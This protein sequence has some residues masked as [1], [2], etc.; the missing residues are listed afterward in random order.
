MSGPRTQDP[1]AV[2]QVTDPVDDLLRALA[3]DLAAALRAM[4]MADAGE[5][6]AQVVVDLGHRADRRARVADG[7]LLVDGDGR[8]QALDLVDVRLLHLAQ[9]LARVRG[10]ALDVATLAL[11]VDGVEG[12]AA[13][14]APGQPG[15]DDQPITRQLDRDVLEVV[16]ARAAHDEGVL[17]H[18]DSLPEDARL[19]QAFDATRRGSSD[20]VAAGPRCA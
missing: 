6:Q 13:L 9:E 15:D 20:G 11:G 5:Q 8:A 14:A 1:G 18:V 4:R 19:E 16:F 12:E 10:Q 3:G 2:R 7:A 17:G